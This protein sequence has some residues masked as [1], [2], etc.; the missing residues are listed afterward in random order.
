MV[1]FMFSTAGRVV[2]SY[3]TQLIFF[4]YTKNIQVDC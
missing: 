4:V 3:S 1:T 2:K